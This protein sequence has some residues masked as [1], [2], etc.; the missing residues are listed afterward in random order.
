MGMPGRLLDEY[1]WSQTSARSL[2]H[3]F[4]SPSVA[5]IGLLFAYP[6]IFPTIIVVNSKHVAL[7]RPADLKLPSSLGMLDGAATPICLVILD[8]KP[9]EHQHQ[10]RRPSSKF[11]GSHTE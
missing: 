9:H 1:E 7:L 10:A 5:Y 8:N 6:V 3:T 2:V 4:N 11:W